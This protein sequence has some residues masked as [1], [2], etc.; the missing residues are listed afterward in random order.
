MQKTEC[1]ERVNTVFLKRTMKG[2]IAQSLS[3]YSL[4]P[5]RLTQGPAGAESHAQGTGGRKVPGQT[6]PICGRCTRESGVLS[7]WGQDGPFCPGVGTTP[8][9]LTGGRGGG[10]VRIPTSYHTPLKNQ[11]EECLKVKRKTATVLEGNRRCIYN[12]G[13]GRQG[14]EPRSHRGKR[15]G[16]LSAT[17]FLASL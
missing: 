15:R 17:T 7:E 11:V 8:C 1:T 2:E 12:L 3:K 6:A 5:R 16:V 4:M 9:P 10:K 14:T 13:A